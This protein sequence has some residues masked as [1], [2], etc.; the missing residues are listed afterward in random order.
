MRDAFDLPPNRD[1]LGRTGL[2]CQCCGRDIVLSVEVL[3]RTLARGSAQRFCGPACRQAAYRRRRADLPEN[4]PTQQQGGRRRNLNPPP[5]TGGATS[6]VT[7]GPIRVDT[8]SR[9]LG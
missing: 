3:F 5:P 8:A 6:G 4:T 1:G 7:L 9:T 2:Q